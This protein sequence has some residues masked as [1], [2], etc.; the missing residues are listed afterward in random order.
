MNCREGNAPVVDSLVQTQQNE[1]EVLEH[2]ALLD[3]VAEEHV[4][5]VREGDERG[6]QH[7]LVLGGVPDDVEDEVERVLVD[8]QVRVVQDDVACSCVPT[9]TYKRQASAGASMRWA[10]ERTSGLL[11]L[12]EQ[13]LLKRTLLFQC[14]ELLRVTIRMVLWVVVLREYPVSVGVDN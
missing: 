11:S 3:L 10:G 9:Q 4:H 1:V 14:R 2:A 7:E 12:L 5:R 6:V 8:R 13:P